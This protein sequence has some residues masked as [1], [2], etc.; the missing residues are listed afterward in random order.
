MHS[1]C[2]FTL[3]CFYEPVGYLAVSGLYLLEQ[4]ECCSRS[5][6]TE[7][8]T[9]TDH[10]RLT[11]SY[12]LSGEDQPICTSCDALLTVKHIL[13]DSAYAGMDFVMLQRIPKKDLETNIPRRFARVES[14]LQYYT[15]CV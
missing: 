14:E 4:M 2:P 11:H 12:L 3:A 15:Q 9:L 8:L 5:P 13:L 10:S 7:A 1:L 6:P